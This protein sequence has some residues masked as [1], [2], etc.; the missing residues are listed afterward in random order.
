MPGHK[1][2]W[3]GLPDRTA[4]WVLF[5]GTGQHHSARAHHQS[6]TDLRL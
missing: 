3:T 1:P 4:A 5:H 6:F 2:D